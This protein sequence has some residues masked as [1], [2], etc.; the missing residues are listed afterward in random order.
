M[1]QTVK[2]SGNI[3]LSRKIR[4]MAVKVTGIQ[5]TE[6]NLKL[7]CPFCGVGSILVRTFEENDHVIWCHC[8]YCGSE[9]KLN[10]PKVIM[11]NVLAK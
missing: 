2:S 4:S 11:Q 5:S 8:N 6:V 7:E 10:S 1:E 9:W 3:M